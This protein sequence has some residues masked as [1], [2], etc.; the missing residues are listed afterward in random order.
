[1]A[2][3]DLIKNR[4][5]S[6]PEM[7]VPAQSGL[8]NRPRL[9]AHV[10]DVLICLVLDVIVFKGVLWLSERT[11][12][13]LVDF[14]LVPLFFVLLCFTILYFWLFYTIFGRTLGGIVVQRWWSRE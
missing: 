13:P 12:G 1:L 6:L 9:L 4:D 5:T 7:E 11:M 8:I 10:L 3:T 14:S 2:A